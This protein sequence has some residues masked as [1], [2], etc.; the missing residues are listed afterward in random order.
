[1]EELDMHYKKVIESLK[2]MSLPYEEQKLYFPDFVEIP[3]EVL[4]TFDNAFLLMPKLI[5]NGLFSNKGIAWVLRLHNTINLL[6]SNPNFKDLEE[7]QFRDNEEWD[8]IR[9]FSKEVLRQLGE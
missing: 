3:F 1:M 6:A 8:K 5:E 9:E 2:L 7:G 4:D